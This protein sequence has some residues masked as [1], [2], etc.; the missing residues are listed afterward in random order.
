MEQSELVPMSLGTPQLQLAPT[1][2]LCMCCLCSATLVPSCHLLPGEGCAAVERT[3]AARPGPQH[4][5]RS[6]GLP[7][8]PQYTGQRVGCKRPKT[9]ADR[10]VVVCI[11]LHPL[12]INRS[13]RHAV[14]DK[15]RRQGPYTLLFA[16]FALHSKPRPLY[17]QQASRMAH[18]GSV[19]TPDICT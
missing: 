16:R 13:G 4:R 1:Q 5:R 6:A 7:E 12:R 19:P 2:K 8:T 9:A 15:P 17:V 3:N 18:A 14:Q 10:E 11:T